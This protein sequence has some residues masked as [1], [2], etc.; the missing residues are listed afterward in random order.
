MAFV[1]GKGTVFKLNGVDLSPFC[2]TSEVTVAADEHDVTGYG[3]A[4]HAYQGG[5][6]NDKVT[7]SGTYDSGVTGPRKVIRPLI[8]TV[9]PFLR[10]SEGVGSGKPQDTGNVHVKTYVETNPVADMIQWSAE[11]TVSGTVNSA[12]Q[13]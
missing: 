8:G 1:H 13:P 3:A 6:E 7:V 10:Q 4:G 9:V 12:A 5:L 2:K 11:L